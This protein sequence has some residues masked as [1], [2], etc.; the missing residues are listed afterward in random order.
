MNLSKNAA[1]VLNHLDREKPKTRAEMAA[2]TGICKANVGM[3][4]HELEING[5]A[6]ARRGGGSA[7]SYTARPEKGPDILFNA[8]FGRQS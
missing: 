5:F 1:L 2:E 7:V 4:L 6:E 3:Y 8:L